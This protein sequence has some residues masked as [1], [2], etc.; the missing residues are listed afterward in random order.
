MVIISVSR[1]LMGLHHLEW[2]KNHLG[3][4]FMLCPEESCHW[5]HWK[6]PLWP[7]RVI[8]D[9]YWVGVCLNQLAPISGSIAAQ[10]C[11]GCVKAQPAET[12]NLNSYCLS[13]TFHFF[14]ALK[15]MLL[16]SHT[17]RHTH[18][19]QRIFHAS[20]YLSLGHLHRD[21]NKDCS[22]SVR[23]KWLPLSIHVYPDS[24]SI[25]LEMAFSNR[26]CT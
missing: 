9:C 11:R 18:F 10:E 5:C 17:T 19:P 24:I 1:K 16:E 12:P 4:Q 13:G 23:L 20:A 26:F 25:T 22:Q 15:H 8:C 2:E 14:W 3:L 6:W 21:H 7:H